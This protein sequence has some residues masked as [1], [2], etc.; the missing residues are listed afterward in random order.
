[1][2]KAIRTKLLNG[3]QS[4]LM[5]F[6]NE[7]NQSKA[8]C[9]AL[10][11]SLQSNDKQNDAFDFRTFVKVQECLERV[12][13]SEE[14]QRPTKLS[15]D[16]CS[17]S[18]HSTLQGHP[19]ARQTVAKLALNDLNKVECSTRP[20]HTNLISNRPREADSNESLSPLTK[21][22]HAAPHFESDD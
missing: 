17:T 14:S 13:A 1:M 18:P 2:C 16:T 5:T 20:C 9:T 22:H 10:L 19:S 21:R 12:A 8:L 7:S 6:V 3:E 4:W 11:N 15:T